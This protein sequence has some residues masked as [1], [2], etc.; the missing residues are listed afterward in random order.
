MTDEDLDA[1]LAAPLPDLDTT[2]FSV[3]LMESIVQRQARPAR[4]LAWFTAG[5]LTVLFAMGC[6]FAA[7]ASGR[8]WVSDPYAIPVVLL[9]LS[10][11]L[12][13]SVLQS[14]RM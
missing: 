9:L 14:A 6:L 3:A 8:G 13:L 1:L 4:V 10:A 5:L 12:S 7:A 2:A 11:G